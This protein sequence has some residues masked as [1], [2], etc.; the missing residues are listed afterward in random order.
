MKKFFRTALDLA[1][2]TVLIL[3]VAYQMD[4]LSGFPKG[5][6][7]YA[8]LTRIRLIDT[9]FPHIN[10]NPF[11]DS[12]TPFSIWSHPPLPMTFTTFFFV[13]LMG[14]TP[15]QALTAMATICF[16]FL[17]WGIYQT[18]LEELLQRRRCFRDFAQLCIG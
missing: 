17:T 4:L 1:L 15:E 13:K 14:L 8:Y 6:D 18:M 16:L 2:I 10:W 9:Y 11:W 12:G 5:N 7:V 3:G